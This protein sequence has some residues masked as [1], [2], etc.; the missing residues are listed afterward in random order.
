LAEALAC[1]PL[2]SA[3]ATERHDPARTA[4]GEMR[5]LP[6][7]NG[8]VAGARADLSANEATSPIEQPTYSSPQRPV[9]V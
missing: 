5:G 4:D 6:A 8:E 9:T 1:E 2:V 7:G 3:E